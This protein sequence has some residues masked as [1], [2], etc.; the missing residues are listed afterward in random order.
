YR[1]RTAHRYARLEGLGQEL[2][3][4]A[5]GLQ[6]FGVPSLRE[7]GT[8]GHVR[9]D[10]VQP[11]PLRAELHRQRP[12]EVDETCLGSGVRGMAGRSPVRLDRRE[13]DDA[14]ASAP[15]ADAWDGEADRLHRPYEVSVDLEC[16]LFE[17][18][19]S[20]VAL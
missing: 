6:R 10:Q 5:T 20:E 9:S 2:R 14:P 19:V 12:A 1:R 13:A 4:Q 7:A 15:R 8:H 11:D 17:R 16:P 18:G 3:A